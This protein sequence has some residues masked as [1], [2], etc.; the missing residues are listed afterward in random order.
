MK[1]LFLYL[2]SI[3]LGLLVFIAYRKSQTISDIKPTVRVYASSSFISQWG[4]GPWLKSEFEKKCNCK[5]EYH[6]AIDSYLMMQKIRSEGPSRGVDLVLGLDDYDLEIAE[7]TLSWKALGISKEILNQGIIAQ[8]PFFPY[9]YSQVAIVYR[10]SAVKNLPKSLQDLALPE[11]KD[12]IALIDPRSSSLGLQF[13]SWI[14]KAYGEEK[15]FELLN[16]I[17]KNVKVYAANWSAAYGLFREK[18]VNLVL[19]YTTSP[20]YHRIE[21]KNLDIQAAQFQEGH[22]LQ[23]EYFGIPQY[24]T[25]CEL[26]LEFAKLILSDVGQKIIM[27]KN[28]MLPILSSVKVNTLFDE[29]PPFASLERSV[30][31]LREREQIIR[32]WNAARKKINDH[33][34]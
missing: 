21:E 32:Q 34:N 10:G 14:V 4:P 28:Y 30:P 23:I 9:D 17:N 8:G 25:Q 26:G 6:E 27:E 31:S 3:F 7:K 2:G 15:G 13:V 24:C 12:Q 22:P 33:S 5:I 19:S 11:F 1:H 29:I 16:Q 20:L 18:Q